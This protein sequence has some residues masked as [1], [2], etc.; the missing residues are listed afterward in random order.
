MFVRQRVGIVGQD[1]VFFKP[2]ARIS[3][4]DRNRKRM[5]DDRGMGHGLDH[6]P[7]GGSSQHIPAITWPVKDQWRTTFRMKPVGPARGETC[8]SWV[9]WH[10]GWPPATRNE[11]PRKV[12]NINDFSSEYG[13]LRPPEK[14]IQEPNRHQIGTKRKR[15]ICWWAS[16]TYRF[17][18]HNW[19]TRRWSQET[20]RSK[21]QGP[22]GIEDRHRDC[23][24]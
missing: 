1:S 2:A 17:R 14:M 5:S 4:E 10:A 19:A 8:L 11:G 12:T 20:P 15:M 7:L 18:S 9:Q 16:T 23:S 13:G 24:P 22:G 6:S 3:E 21:E